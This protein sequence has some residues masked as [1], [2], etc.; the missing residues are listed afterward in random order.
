MIDILKAL[1]DQ[2]R[3][4]ILKLL[5]RQEMGVCEIMHA[6]GLSQPAVSHHLKILKQAGLVCTEKQGKMVFY[7][8]NKTGLQNFFNQ[9]NLF[10]HDL[11]CFSDTMP[12]SSPLRQNPNM[13]ETLG[14]KKSVCE[15]DI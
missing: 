4:N 11:H 1:A 9:V 7:T 14:Y 12:G 10:L 6:I 2:H 8:L 3:Q 5:A 15:K 13:C